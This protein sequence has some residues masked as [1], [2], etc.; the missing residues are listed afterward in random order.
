MKI[1][2]DLIDVATTTSNGLMSA[3][4]KTKLD[5]IKIYNANYEFLHTTE[6]YINVNWL[7]SHLFIYG[8]NGGANNFFGTLFHTDNAEVSQITGSVP[9]FT[10]VNNKKIKIKMKSQMR[11][12]N[13]FR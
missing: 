9:T 10:W 3:S 11:T 8:V 6:A 5:N 2:G 4:D 1:N 7:Y 13:S 12:I